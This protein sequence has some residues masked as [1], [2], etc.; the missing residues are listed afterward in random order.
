M[1][2]VNLL[3]EFSNMLCCDRRA[4]GVTLSLGVTVRDSSRKTLVL[5]GFARVC[6]GGFREIV[7]GRN[8]D[9][10]NQRGIWEI[11]RK[12]VRRG[13]GKMPHRANTKALDLGN[14]ASCHSA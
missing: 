3:P 12:P 8:M 7:G 4:R 13:A 11:P 1:R 9:S 10:R 14:R 5:Q 2:V 6:N